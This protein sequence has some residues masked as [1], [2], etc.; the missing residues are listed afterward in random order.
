MLASNARTGRTEFAV[1]PLEEMLEEGHKNKNTRAQAEA[2]SELG[3]I[4]R[5]L[6]RLQDAENAYRETIPLFEKLRHITGKG[7]VLC[8]LG[9]TLEQGRNIE[10]AQPYY[11]QSLRLFEEIGDGYGEAKLWHC[12]ARV[13]HWH[14]N[15]QLALELYTKSLL[16]YREIKHIANTGSIL[17]DLA[18]LQIDLNQLPEAS[19]LCEDAIEIFEGLDDQTAIAM[20]LS[21]WASFIIYKIIWNLR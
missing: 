18:K 5:R 19:P 6:G 14:G 1:Q 10:D 20:S 17:V 16:H 9:M 11:Q 2:L 4:Y 21:I 15:Y 13:R 8:G 12:L 3:L 7:H